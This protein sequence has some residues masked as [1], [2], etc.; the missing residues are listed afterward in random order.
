M[1]AMAHGILT[2]IEFKRFVADLQDSCVK[3]NLKSQEKGY[4]TKCP[5]RKSLFFSI[6]SNV[7]QFF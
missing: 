5:F 3:I 7:E 2:K 6:Q 1:V 4:L